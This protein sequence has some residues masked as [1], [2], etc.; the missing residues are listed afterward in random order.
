MI[1]NKPHGINLDDKLVNEYEYT[2]VIVGRDLSSYLIALILKQHGHHVAIVSRP[3]TPIM[4][5]LYEYLSLKYLYEAA[6]R[7]RS[8]QS[9]CTKG[10]QFKF[11]EKTSDFDWQQ[12]THECK[13]DFFETKQNLEKEI[14]K[15][16]ISIYE[17]TIVM[18]EDYVLRI[19]SEGIKERKKKTNNSIDFSLLTT[20]DE[21]T[22]IA[23]LRTKHVIMSSDICRCT[24]KDYSNQINHN[25]IL[26]TL[27]DIIHLDQIPKSLTVVGGGTVGTSVASCMKELGCI[28]VTIIERQ[29]H[30]LMSINHIDREIAAYIES[31]LIKQQ[32]NIITKCAVNYLTETEPYSTTDSIKTDYQFIALGT[33]RKL[34]TVHNIPTTALI[35]LIERVSFGRKIQLGTTMEDEHGETVVIPITP[36]VPIDYQRVKSFCSIEQGISIAYRTIC[37]CLNDSKPNFVMPS[38]IFTIPPLLLMGQTRIPADNMFI[39]RVTVP[40]TIK[41]TIDTPPRGFGKL[42]ISRTR[43]ILCGVQLVSEHVFMFGKAFSILIRNE[44]SLNDLCNR[45]ELPGSIGEVV[46]IMIKQAMYNINKICYTP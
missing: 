2:A 33:K 10:F 43:K 46:Q 29:L 38:F 45:I 28:S 15:K 35:Q 18:I 14:L 21:L 6:Q 36:I 24:T 5:D 4:V 30:C 23:V 26:K 8:I 19:I 17:G 16:D 9:L 25:R 13:Q 12:L 27:V 40:P 1:N 39:C 3:N 44:I 34:N 20:K 11:D 41:Y 7:L 42:W 22:Q 32:I 31:I 37:Q